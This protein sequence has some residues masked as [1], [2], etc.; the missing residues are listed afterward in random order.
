MPQE[1]KILIPET[2]KNESVDI[3]V[4]SAEKTLV[5]YRLEVFLY[6][7]ENTNQSRADFLKEQIEQYA[8]DYE[9]VEIGL[10]GNQ[11]IPVLF[12]QK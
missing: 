3:K 5:D 8:A 10:D 9:V 1:V 2:G 6:P 4:M 12:R 7:A 11:M